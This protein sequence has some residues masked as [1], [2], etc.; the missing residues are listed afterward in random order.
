MSTTKMDEKMENIDMNALNTQSSSENIDDSKDVESEETNNNSE[1]TI[2]LSHKIFMKNSFLTIKLK[3]D[4]NVVEHPDEYLLR[5]KTKILNEVNNLLANI[6]TGLVKINIKF[7]I[8][9]KN[10]VKIINIYMMRH[11]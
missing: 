7:S 6:F 9:M 4:E 1:R 5:N 11:I 10:C 2:I 3:T 8:K